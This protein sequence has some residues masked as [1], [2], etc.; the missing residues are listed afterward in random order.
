MLEFVSSLISA[1]D[2]IAGELIAGEA[3]FG[4]LPSWAL[5]FFAG[6]A[7]LSGGSL[8]SFT[9]VL[10]YR[11]PLDMSVVSP[12]SACPHCGHQIRWYQN[13]PLLSYL[14]LR[15]RCGACATSISPRYFLVELMG[16]A[17][18]LM[19]GARWVWP[20]LSEP[21]R[22]AHS[23]EQLYASVGL[24]L[25]QLCFVCALIA[26]TL[27]DL[28]HT[29]IPDEL[30]LP[31]TLIGVWGSF[32]L[33]TWLPQH[34][35]PLSALFGALG[36]YLLIWGVR[37]LG[38]V[39]YRRE[40]MGLGDAKLLAMIGAF[41]GLES[42]PMILLFASLQGILAALIA[43]AYTRLTGRSNQ[44]TMTTRELDERFGDE[45][46]DEGAQ[47]AI[48]FGPFLALSAFEWLSVGELT[49]PLLSLDV[50]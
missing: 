45:T 24:W 27:I 41:L 26:V 47:L 44:L 21:S 34:L 16:A 13:I 17:W 28:E 8:A 6:V 30:S 18:G 36:G 22:W 12:P 29:F 43:L 25:W 23:P 7:L 49:L 42:L 31:T 5:P 50:M 38:F 35:S 48:P 1:G 37:G 15:G 32:T 10:I 20:L 40:A 3:S 9:N 46:L 2:I 19:L 39:M 11:L 4:A 14:I 33:A